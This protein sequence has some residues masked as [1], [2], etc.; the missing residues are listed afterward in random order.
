MHS[1]RT[2]AKPTIAIVGGET[3][4]GKEVRDLFEASDLDASIKLI[5]SDAAEEKII[6][7]RGRDEPVVIN[8]LLASDIGTAKIV[9]LAGSP[10]T[11]R[12]AYEKIQKTKPPPQV[13]D[14]SGSL[15]DRPEARLRA[16]LVEGPDHQVSGTIQ[17]IAH[18]ASI[19]LA[20]LLTH[21]Q[22]A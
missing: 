19:A 22:K 2:A 17:V 16:P 8:S 9:I 11:G 12:K 13:I 6:L 10:E 21:L 20:M 7:A 3:L 18:P 14:L 15:E 1:H 4:L 5:A